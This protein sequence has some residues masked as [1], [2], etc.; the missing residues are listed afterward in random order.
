MA[1]RHAKADSIWRN[2]RFMTMDPERPYAEAVAVRDGRILALGSD[3][4]I[5]ALSGPG[6]R[7][8]LLHGRFAMPGLIDTHVH[9]LWGARRDLFEV[10]V[11][12][13]A[14]LQELLDGVRRRAATTPPG[15]WIVGGP[16]RPTHA[17]ELG[18]APRAVLDR[19]A[20]DHP[21]ALGDVTQHSL[22]VS[23]RALAAAGIDRETPDPFD[24]RIERDTNREPTGVLHES[25]AG[26][27]RTAQTETAARMAAAAGYVTETFHR[28]G[29]TGFKEPMAFEPDLAAYREADVR[30]GLHLH[31]SCCLTRQ[32]PIGGAPTP[33]E[34]LRRWRIDYA[35]DNVRTDCAKLFLD[36]VA[37][38]FT[39][40]FLE[41]YV[42][43]GYD[44]ARHDP[45]AL[46]IMPP[47]RIADEVA[48][49]DAMGFTVK[50]HAVG[51][52]AVRAGLDAIAAARAAN[53]ESGLRHE[54]AHCGF[55]A[56]ADLPRFA[57]L[58]AVAE[59]SPKMWFPNPVTAG[60]IAVLGEERT[61]RCH[62]IRSLLD[63][64]A[65]VTYGSD[66][67]A[68][69]PD[70]DP[71]I[72][73]AGML[74][75]RDPTGRY[76]G[77]VGPG[78]AISLMQALRIFTVNGAGALGRGGEI[79]ALKVDHSADFI[80]LDRDIEKVAPQSIA[81]VEVQKTIFKGELRRDLD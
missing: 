43:P 73:L 57:A 78:E 72:G 18:E 46:L 81:E 48:A 44:S 21:V 54:L 8:H 32:S 22:W 41:A 62:R 27:V 42:A 55:I 66:W 80:V 10:Y 63:A 5:A 24:G 1:A 47:A 38:S 69:A 19:I 71:W 20:P 16:W 29:V 26:R 45:A 11:G 3:A 59:V 76:P 65:T 23:S 56:D 14:S 30:D 68:A 25:A 53:G 33:Y 17:A 13:A 35:T 39:A 70:P 31:V 6:T 2:G 4:D 40:S 9:A 51:D 77:V 79:G 61:Q 12:Y 67:P 37:P 58:G 52:G 49:L 60:Q 7:T 50:M 75:R 15:E 74:T 34:E 28:L 64:G 36:G